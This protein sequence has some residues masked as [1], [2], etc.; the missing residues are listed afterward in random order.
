MNFLLLIDAR[1]LPASMVDDGTGIQIW[2]DNLRCVGTERRLVDCPHNGFGSHNCNHG[3]DV[4]VICQQYVPGK[5]EADIDC[6]LAPL[7]CR[8]S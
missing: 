2:L 8:K 4:G 5:T 3:E 6:T 7:I 1:V